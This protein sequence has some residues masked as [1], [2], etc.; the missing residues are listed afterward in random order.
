MP[1][2][3][4]QQF[5]MEFP[6]KGVAGNTIFF[7]IPNWMPGYYQLMNSQFVLKIFSASHET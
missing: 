6:V 2:L 4:N 7:I 1:Q 3:A 5:Y